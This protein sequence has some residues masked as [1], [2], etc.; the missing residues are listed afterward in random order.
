MALGLNI[1]SEFMK[2]PPTYTFDKFAAMLLG[3]NILSEFMKRLV[4]LAG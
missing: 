1:L 2:R 3:L 4:Q